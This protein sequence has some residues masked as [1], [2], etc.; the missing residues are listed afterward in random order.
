MK[1]LKNFLIKQKNIIVEEQ[2]NEIIKRC[3]ERIRKLK[4]ILEN[5]I[6]MGKEK[7]KIKT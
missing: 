1:C 7:L 2:Y 3:S 5:E 4:K 6:I